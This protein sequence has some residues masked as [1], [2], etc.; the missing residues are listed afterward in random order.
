VTTDHPTNGTTTS[1]TEI[2]D[3]GIDQSLPNDENWRT[4]MG[5]MTSNGAEM[6]KVDLTQVENFTFDN[7]STIE[8]IV[9]AYDTGETLIQD[10][11]GNIATA[12]VV[13]GDLF[14]VQR[15][16]THY[17]IRVDVVTETPGDNND[18]YELSI[19]F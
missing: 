8:Q 17:L 2:R 16:G 18:S 4:Q 1:D 7:A 6:R 12:V 14:V 19:K 10:V 9:G 3:M 15:G 13:A 5:P 11:G